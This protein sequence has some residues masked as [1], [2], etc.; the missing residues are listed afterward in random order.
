VILQIKSYNFSVIYTE[1]RRYFI[2]EYFLIDIHIY[3]SIG[4]RSAGAVDG[5]G[6]MQMREQASNDEDEFEDDEE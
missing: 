6:G 2:I 1:E 5:F 3:I 4:S